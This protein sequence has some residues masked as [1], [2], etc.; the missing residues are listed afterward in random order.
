MALWGNKDNINSSGTVTLNYANL[1]VTGTGTTFG[2]PGNAQPGDV[3]RFGTAFSGSQTFFGDAVIVSIANT[4]SLRIQTTDG[5]S[6]SLITNQ[7]YQISQSPKYLPTDAAQNQSSGSFKD[8]FVVKLSTFTPLRV[9]VGTTAVNV[10]GNLVTSE[11]VAGDRVQYESWPDRFNY[12]TVHSVVGTGTV[13]LVNGIFESNAIYHTP[14]NFPTAPVGF[15]TIIVTER[16]Y[17]TD[18]D[19]DPVT[20]I[21]IGDGV[22]VGTNTGLTITAI[23]ENFPGQR[24]LTLSGTLTQEVVAGAVVDISRG[25]A[26]AAGIKFAATEVLEGKESV[27]VGIATAGTDAALG[28]LYQLT[29]AGWVG[30]T[31]YTD[32]D[33]N[34]RVKTETFVAMSGIQTGNTP[35]PP[36]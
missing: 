20:D 2:T 8:T 22:D 34:A 19:I 32:T 6:G 18:P 23:T 14:N 12:D 15:S 30:V 21:K 17:G 33:G 27:T 3:I 35:Y 26:P 1:T 10:A 7:P 25:L 28:T 11:V 13:F 29:A 9:A 16:A 31:T 5:L 24:K 36:A 4:Q